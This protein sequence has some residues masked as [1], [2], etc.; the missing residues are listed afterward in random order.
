M[1]DRSYSVDAN[2]AVADGAAPQTLSGYAQNGG[3]DGIVDLGGNQSITALMPSI[4]DVS[5]L[6]TQQA[7]IEGF[8]VID[9]TAVKTSAGNELYRFFLV[10]SN[11]PSFASAKFACLGG[12]EFGPIA[13]FVN[14]I[15]TPAPFAVGAS[16]YETG[17]CNEQNNIKYG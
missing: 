8:L 17:F 12:F 6:S 16:R 15:V 1:G 10:G 2:M 7:R 3:A 14:P 4:A 11:D 9:L 13:D 5:L